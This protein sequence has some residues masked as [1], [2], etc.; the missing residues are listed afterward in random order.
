MSGFVGIIGQTLDDV[1]GAAG[2]SVDVTITEDV[3]PATS[4]P[5]GSRVAM[6]FVAYGPAM[7][8]PSQDPTD[9]DPGW[10]TD[11]GNGQQITIEDNVADPGGAAEFQVMGANQ[12]GG[13][14]VSYGDP[15]ERP[16]LAIGRNSIVGPGEMEVGFEGLGLTLFPQI[17]SIDDATKLAGIGCIGPLAVYLYWGYKA[18]DVVTVNFAE[19][20]AHRHVTI[21]LF[22]GYGPEQ[23]LN[24][25]PDEGEGVIG[26]SPVPLGGNPFPGLDGAEEIGNP[27]MIAEYVVPVLIGGI[28]LDRN[29][30]TQAWAPSSYFPAVDA[31][32][33]VY[34]RSLDPGAGYSA[35][36]YDDILASGGFS[37]PS[38]QIGDQIWALMHKQVVDSVD[39]TVFFYSNYVCD[40]DPWGGSYPGVAPATVWYDFGGS[41]PDPPR[42]ACPPWGVAGAVYAI[43]AEYQVY[44]E[45]PGTPHGANPVMRNGYYLPGFDESG[46]D[47]NAPDVDDG[48][49]T[50]A[51]GIVIALPNDTLEMGQTWTRLDG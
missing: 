25:G 31:G 13:T 41:R 50:A 4:D 8:W 35:H 33:S 42:P 43:F 2:S 51:E 20:A 36:A 1:G 16:S 14:D 39:P 24:P 27:G 9:G 15:V 45:L 11:R 44:P 46:F 22:D 7:N 19:A 17:V 18:G 29:F 34:D 37:G 40:L 26:E 12:Y 48:D 23:G 10:G 6:M 3:D 32:D 28:S 30:D 5:A 49:P 47:G 21:L 38:G